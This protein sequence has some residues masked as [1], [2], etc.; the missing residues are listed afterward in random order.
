MSGIEVYPDYGMF[1]VL[2]K[3]TQGKEHCRSTIVLAINRPQA[4]QFL[5]GPSEQ[6]ACLYCARGMDG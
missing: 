2:E 3:D 1:R 6:R 4:H 5:L